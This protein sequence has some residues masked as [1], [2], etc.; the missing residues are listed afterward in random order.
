MGAIPGAVLRHAEEAGRPHREPGDARQE[1]LG[2]R[3]PPPGLGRA[4]ASARDRHDRARPQPPAVH[5]SVG[6]RGCTD[7]ATLRPDDGELV[8]TA[9]L[10]ADVELYW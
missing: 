10:A 9:R 8:N 1:V 6:Q 5:R 7:D 4:Q 2:V 3:V